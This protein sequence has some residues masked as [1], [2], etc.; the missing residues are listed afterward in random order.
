MNAIKYWASVIHLDSFK[1][2]ITDCNIYLKLTLCT[3]EKIIVGLHL[4]GSNDSLAFDLMMLSFKLAKNLQDPIMALQCVS[5]L[6]NS[7]SYSEEIEK[8]NLECNSY[9]YE[10]L[11]ND[12][13]KENDKIFAYD[14][15]LSY[16]EYLLNC[17]NLD[18]GE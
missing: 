16:V 1:N 8:I 2:D 17:K 13:S 15:L 10:V 5:R 7:L 9:V 14:Y 18:K 3:M 4:R 11:K 6:I 12:D